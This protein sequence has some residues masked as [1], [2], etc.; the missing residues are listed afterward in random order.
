MAGKRIAQIQELIKEIEVLQSQIVDEQQLI[1]DLKDKRNKQEDC[2]NQKLSKLEEKHNAEVAKL[3][4][5]KQQI[6]N[7][8]N[9]TE[10]KSL[11]LST[12]YNKKIE[13]LKKKI[14]TNKDTFTKTA[15]DLKNKEYNDALKQHELKEKELKDNKAALTSKYREESK[16][17]HLKYKELIKQQ[18]D[19]NKALKLEEENYI[20]AKEE[21]IA[22]INQQSAYLAEQ[23]DKLLKETISNN[24]KVLDE[25]N[26]KTNKVLSEKENELN[27]LKDQLTSSVKEKEDL[28]RK[29]NEEKEFEENKLK[30]MNDNY[31]LKIDG[32]FQNNETLE[33]ILHNKEREVFE[34]AREYTEEYNKVKLEEEDNDKYLVSEKEK[35]IAM[36][37]DDYASK[38]N[39]LSERMEAVFGEIANEYKKYLSV[40]EL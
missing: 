18:E 34:K 31:N 8:I 6:Q 12:A 7:N 23:Q 38:K 16:A 19:N 26:A 35:T 20:K 39:S 10:E 40:I 37:E 13:S 3:N 15:K 28:E 25:L 30:E 14:K 32:L 9:K 1:S 11:V 5:K 36:L 33:N 2:F 4:N 29:L 22:N 27:A 17:L 24:T 21:T